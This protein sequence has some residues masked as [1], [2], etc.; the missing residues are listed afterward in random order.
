MSSV[1]EK[2][3]DDPT[4]KSLKSYLEMGKKTTWISCAGEDGGSNQTMNQWN[5]THKRHLNQV[6]KMITHKSVVESDKSLVFIICISSCSEIK[7]IRSFVKDLSENIGGVKQLAFVYKKEAHF[8]KIKEGLLSDCDSSTERI[9]LTKD[10]ASRCINID[11]QELKI[12]IL[13]H[14]RHG[15]I[16]DK[17]VISSSGQPVP[18]PAKVIDLYAQS[19]LHILAYNECDNLKGDRGMLEA[20]QK[21]RTEFLE[22]KPPEWSLFFFH[23]ESQRIPW[24]REKIIDSLVERDLVKRVVT[25]LRHAAKMKDKTISIHPIDH[26]PNT[27]ATTLTR[28]VLWRLR[29]EFRCV[30]MNR[31]ANE[32]LDFQDVAEKLIGFREMREDRA[33]ANGTTMGKSCN[34]FLFLLDNATSDEMQIVRRKVEDLIVEGNIQ[35]ETTVGMILYVRSG[36]GDGEEDDQ[37][38]HVNTKFTKNEIMLFKKKHEEFSI[39]KTNPKNMFGFILFANLEKESYIQD[40][41]ME[42]L[43]DMGSYPVQILLILYLAIFK[44]FGDLSISESHC[45]HILGPYFGEMEGWMEGRK[46]LYENLCEN[47]HMFIQKSTDVRF[48]GQVVLEIN[49]IEAA[50]H[51]VK[52]SLML[53]Q[54]KH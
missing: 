21:C 45:K 24:G 4:G 53:K 51:L 33:I 8:E 50:K 14:S 28:H 2:L 23:E 49:S 15:T 29:E 52:Q 48:G 37:N 42:I 12:Y 26:I 54:E 47:A 27:G 22:G 31:K 18:I 5:N 35:F 7:K 34:P 10:I 41:T 19:G 38:I 36:R 32:E 13:K 16:S 6:V 17:L 3:D 39:E 46:D 43:Q 1:A 30:M 20:A 40:V 44:Y 11:W 25:D 9:E